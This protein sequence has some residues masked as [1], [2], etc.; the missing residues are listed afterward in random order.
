MKFHKTLLLLPA[1]FLSIMVIGSNNDKYS[2][3]HIGYATA[4][5]NTNATE[6]FSVI[7]PK[8]SA[9]P[10][11]D[12]TKLGPRQ[13]YLPGQITIRVNDTITWTNNDTQVHTVPLL[14]KLLWYWSGL[15]DQSTFS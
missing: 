4:K 5:A 1:F 15:V 14:H 7:I 6:S 3:Y 9:N 2:Y 13:W 11:I 12:I 8:G 10:E